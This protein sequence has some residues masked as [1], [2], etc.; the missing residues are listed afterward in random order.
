MSR[1]HWLAVA[2]VFLMLAGCGPATSRDGVD[3]ACS[4]IVFE[5]S[6]FTACRARPGVH[7]LLL[8]DRAAGGKPMRDFEGLPA[9]LGARFPKLAFAMNA[10][11]FDD[12][13]QPIGYYVED[14][15]QQAPLNRRPG[16][17]NF[18]MQPNGVFWGDAKGWHVAATDSF[19]AAKPD[20]V[21]F[22]TQSGPMLIV[23][24]KLHPQIAPNGTSL[25]IRNGVG[26]AADGS[27]WF[28]ISDEAV[29]FGRFARLFRERLG[30]ANAL[31]L[32]G[33]VSRLWDPVAARKDGGAAIGPIVVALQKN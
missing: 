13:G 22:A 28:A 29:S 21:R 25:Q 3:A 2:G 5:E 30:C 6:T 4:K 18:H 32:D 8:V 20:H 23:D 16:P 19:A 10:G 11:M 9:R 24:G 33:K 1:L 26:V 31:F 15:E 14:G 27:A 7:E 17:G 12:K